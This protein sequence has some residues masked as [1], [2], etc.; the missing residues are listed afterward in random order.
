MELDLGGLPGPVGNEPGGDYPPA[1]LLQSIVVTLPD[2]AGVFRAGFLA[3]GVQDRLDRLR[4]A[5]GQVA[6]QP[7]GA[8]QGGPQPDLPVLEPGLA[9]TGVRAQALPHL[10]GQRAQVRQLRAARRGSEQDQVRVVAG[11]LREQVRPV[12]NLPRPRQ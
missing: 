4:A 3:Q 12:A 1:R 8:A 9:V 2:R 11:G 10:R 6:V 5:L 7:A